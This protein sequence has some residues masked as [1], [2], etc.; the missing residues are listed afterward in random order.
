[1]KTEI[2]NLTIKKMD[3]EGHGLAKIA[4]LSAID[5]D[6]DTY[7]RGAFAWK[8]GGQQW[9]SILPAHNRT[10]M[11]LGKARIYEEGDAALAE[12]HLNLKSEAG[13]EWHAALK[14]D[15]EKGNAVQEW[16]YGFGVVDAAHEQRGDDRIRRL[17]RLDVHEVSPVVRG[18]GVGTGTLSLKSHGSFAEQ[19]D[20]AIEAIDDIVERAGGVKA[21]READGRHMS[22]AR[23][24][25]L[26]ALKGRLE[27]LLADGPAA[28]QDEAKAVSALETI[29]VALNVAPRWRNPGSK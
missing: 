3:E 10:A 15:L 25:Q 9:V 20:A 17:K 19:I 8:E 14:F 29:A 27:E 21:L 28:T 11:P 26:A 22:K 13:R 5:H 6:G 1:M 18:A 7:D 24:D 12:L 2:K 16:S 4:T 23:I